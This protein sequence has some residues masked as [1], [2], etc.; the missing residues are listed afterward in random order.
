VKGFEYWFPRP[1]RD[2]DEKPLVILGGGRE[3]TG[4]TFELYIDDD[5]T[6]NPKV[7]EVLRA[8]LPAVF[9]GKFDRGNDPDMEWVRFRS[10]VRCTVPFQ[11]SPDLDRYHGLYLNW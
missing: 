1:V 11:S 5:S 3:A 10:S 7:G 8:F 4:P 6:C 9:E 2:V